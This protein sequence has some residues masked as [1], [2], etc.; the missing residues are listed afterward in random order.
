MSEVTKETLWI[1]EGYL[2]EFSG[3]F[4]REMEDLEAK[5]YKHAGIELSPDDGALQS[6]VREQ[7]MLRLGRNL[8]HFHWHGAVGCLHQIMINGSTPPRGSEARR[9][10][11]RLKRASRKKER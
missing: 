5:Y 8:T 6:W 1:V 7:I 2:R 10:Y 11:D 4:H 3:K 9:Q